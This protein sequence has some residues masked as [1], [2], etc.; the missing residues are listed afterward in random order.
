VGLSCFCC[1]LL[2]VVGSHTVSSETVHGSRGDGS[3]R[4]IPGFP[5]LQNVLMLPPVAGLYWVY[6]SRSRSIADT[7]GTA[8]PT[9]F[10]IA[11]EQ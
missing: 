6:R 9:G 7:G 11:A 3:P 5:V 4:I 10:V 2:F 1:F 8:L